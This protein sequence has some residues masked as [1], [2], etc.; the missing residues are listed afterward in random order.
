MEH[1]HFVSIAVIT[2]QIP[3]IMPVG[4]LGIGLRCSYRRYRE[5]SEPRRGII[6]EDR[7]M[8][9]IVEIRALP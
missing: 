5:F 4:N 7:S 6:G 1:G 2:R 8:K 3:G 9:R